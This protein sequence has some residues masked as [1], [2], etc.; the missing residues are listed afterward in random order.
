MMAQ[1]IKVRVR[2]K[3]NKRK[4]IFKRIV[5]LFL[6]LFVCAGAFAGYKIINTLNAVDKTYNELDRGDKSKLRESVVEMK[7]E[8]FSILFMGIEDYSTGGQDGH[9]DSL[10]L[11]TLDPK[12]KTMKMISI[13]RDT[14]TEIAGQNGLVT[15]ITHAYNYGGKEATIETVENLLGIPI[16]YYAMV[17]FKGFKDVVDEIGGID[18]DVPFDFTEESDLSKN[19]VIEFKKGPMHLNGEEALAYARMRKQDPR[20]DFGRNDRQKQVI[21]AAIDQMS[22]PQNLTNIDN[23][24]TAASKNIETN[25]KITQ[26]LGLH[27]IYSG[28]KSDSIETLTLEGSDVYLPNSS[29]QNIYYFEPDSEKLQTLSTT[30]RQHLKLESGGTTGTASNSDSDTETDAAAPDTESKSS[31]ENNY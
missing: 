17:G 6:L 1:R 12:E 21:A 10:I 13:P 16:D 4:I 20:G 24:T 26:A 14:R 3:K 29:G 9:T 30:L 18:V 31:D 2:K 11:A 23:I 19:K 8:P 22:K 27:K 7:Q 5:F 25:I 28:F 15:K